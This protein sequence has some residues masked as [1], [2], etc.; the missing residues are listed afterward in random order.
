MTANPAGANQAPR[1]RRGALTGLDERT[2]ETNM[3]RPTWGVTG[4]LAVCGILAA[5]SGVVA[6]T[7]VVRFVINDDFPGDGEPGVRSDGNP[8]YADYR[9]DPI[10]PVNWCVD[11]APYSQGLLF[12]RLNRKLDGDAGVQRCSDYPD[13][14]G[15]NMAIPRNIT[16]TID[17][18]AV[19][20]LLADPFAGLTVTDGGNLAWNIGSSSPPC[21]LATNDNPRIRLDTLYIARAKTTT[22]DFQTEMFGSPVSYVI[23]SDTAAGWRA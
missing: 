5:W 12:V 22:I 11:A 8:V 9:I 10:P 19:C 16:L 4:A 13:G 15:V 3:V 20:D 2:K 17:D 21:T 14:G 6:A 23:R 1:G 18:D 7:T